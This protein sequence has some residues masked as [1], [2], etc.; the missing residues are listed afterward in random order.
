MQSVDGG[1]H[2]NVAPGISPVKVDVFGT[3]APGAQID[4]VAFL[5]GI[6]FRFGDVRKLVRRKSK[7]T[8]APLMD[9]LE[10]FRIAN[11]KSVFDDLFIK[12]E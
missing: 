1:R 12:I 6:E 10:N 3:D 11:P 2:P 5:P 8:K 9:F 7:V 4:P